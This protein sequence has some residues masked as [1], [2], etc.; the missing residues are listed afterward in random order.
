MAV[1]LRI[2]ITIDPE[3]LRLADRQARR[4]KTSRS[5]V[6]RA[7]VRALATNHE[8]ESEE[9]DR[10]KR[11]REAAATMDRLA[12]EFGSWPAQKILRASRDRWAKRKR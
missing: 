2:N 3:T 1:K 5:E 9:E 6:F 10:R 11:Q 7:G 12:H 4:Q 8:R